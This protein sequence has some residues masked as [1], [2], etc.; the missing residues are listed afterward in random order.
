MIE[1]TKR[2]EEDMSLPIDKR[3]Y[4]TSFP[5][6]E[7]CQTEDEVKN[8]VRNYDHSLIQWEDG[9]RH[10]GS[11]SV[12]TGVMVDIDGPSNTTPNGYKVPNVTRQQLEHYF[13][14]VN[15]IIYES[16]SHQIEKNGF[17]NDRHHIMFPF[18]PSERI[19]DLKEYKELTERLKK[20]FP[21]IDKACSDGARFYF[22]SPNGEIYINLDKEKSIINIVADEDETE[23]DDASN[24]EGEGRNNHLTKYAGILITRNNLNEEQVRNLIL[25][26]N[27]RFPKPLSEKELEKTIFKSIGRWIKERNTGDSVFFKK[28]TRT[29]KIK[30]S[31]L[32]KTY[33]EQ[34]IDEVDKLSDNYV[35]VLGAREA[36][37]YD[38]VR[39]ELLN[40]R[41]FLEYQKDYIVFNGEEYLLSAEYWLNHTHTYRQLKHSDKQEGEVIENGHKYYNI[42]SK[43]P[44]DVVYDMNKTDMETL[45]DDIINSKRDLIT[46]TYKGLDKNLDGGLDRGYVYIIQAMTG[47]WKS[48][49]TMNMAIRMLKQQLRILFVS[50]EINKRKAFT[51]FI[52][53][54]YQ[55]TAQELKL[56]SSLIGDHD[57]DGFEFMKIPNSDKTVSD[58]CEMSN[59]VKNGDD[60]DVVFIDLLNDLRPEHATEQH[61]KI[62]DEIVKDLTRMAERLDCV[63]IATTQSN[64]Q[65]EDKSG[66]DL[67]EKG[68]STVGEGYGKAFK[69][70]G[71]FVI[72]KTDVEDERVIIPIKLRD[73]EYVGPTRIKLKYPFI[74]EVTFTPLI[75]PPP[76]T[77]TYTPTKKQ[78][79]FTKE[80]LDAIS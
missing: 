30:K 9:Y 36:M 14:D 57:W 40:R 70:A 74:E 31:T 20:Q 58:I 43:V 76:H 51:R 50:T 2:H 33:K 4:L 1:L 38:K 42:P 48:L 5:D 41:Q 17:K 49:L 15:Y 16:K 11:F 13:K 29:Q 27:Q 7:Y 53:L 22:A 28:G 63:V 80:L 23:I 6:V 59:F 54:R 8:I 69:S 55:K 19:Y 37:I 66:E 21:F 25:I 78:D 61:W 73:S 71:Y 45:V 68:F 79:S 35:Y 75:T 56:Q 64:R 44:T 77:P 72:Q 62:P 12:A 60:I 39:D 46:T 47:S 24:I 26:E 32:L 65:Q 3:K 10:E 67:R 52:P 34:T 18:K